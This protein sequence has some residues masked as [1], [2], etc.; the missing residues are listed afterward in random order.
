MTLIV[1]RVSGGKVYILGDTELTFHNKQKVNPFVEGCLKQY[2]VSDRL[3][4]G[5]AGVREHFEQVLPALLDCRSGQ[6][7]V[8]CALNAQAEGLNFDLLVGEVGYEK[9]RFAKNG[10]LS[11]SEAGYLGSAEAFNAFQ[12]YY[13]DLSGSRLEAETGR[14]SIQVLKLPEPVTDGDT[15]H[16]LFA[17]F[18]NVIWD[19]EATGVGGL[20][21]SLCTDGG[22]FRYLHYADVTSDPLRIEDFG[23]EPKTIEFGTAAGGG[24]S[25]EFGDDTPYG[26]EGR[27]VGLYFLQ[28]GFGVVFP[29][30]ENGFRNAQ[31]VR[32]KNPA[33]WVLETS[34]RLGHGISS[35]YMSEDHCGMVGEE[36][37]QAGRYA[38]ALRCYEL[39]KDSKSLPDRPKVYDRYV[40]GYA[41]AMFN[42]GRPFEA[43][44][45]LATHLE[46]HRQSP[47]CERMMEKMLRAGEN[48]PF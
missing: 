40:A 12:T 20:I 22:R 25:V 4:I 46:K 16:R 32:A 21:V 9:I 29:P 35:M 26:G 3:A 10:A 18:K 41:T 23:E 27:N 19:S 33:F 6:E 38:D 48:R 17:S 30:N 24:Y 1:G 14:A 28:G 8:E 42:C 36:L 43:I 13:H 45:M 31:L 5:F 39:R 15:Y 44:D 11:E 37:L 7:L 34:K 2:L 47:Y